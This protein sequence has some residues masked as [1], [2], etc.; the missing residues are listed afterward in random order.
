MKTPH[1]FLFRLSVLL[2]FA[3]SA[4]ILRAASLH[5]NVSFDCEK[6]YINVELSVTD[7]QSAET[8]L[9]LPVWAPGYYLIVDYPKNVVDFAVKDAAGNDI[10]WTKVN[11]NGWNIANG[12]N[13]E[14]TVTYR[15]YANAQSVAEA[16]VKPDKAFVPINGVLMYVENEKDHPVTVTFDLPADWKHISTGL[17]KVEG[18]PHTYTAPSFDVL[19]DC[20]VYLG[21][22]TLIHFDVEGRPYELALETP[23]DIENT[24]FVEDLKKMIAT[25]T[26]MIGHV[27]YHHYTFILMGAGR[28]GLEHTNSQACFTDG[29]FW[30]SDRNYYLNFFSFITHEFFHLYNVKTI[31]PIELGP[32]DYDREVHTPSLWISEGFTVYYEPLLMRRAGLITQAEALAKMSEWLGIIENSEGRK[33]MSL[34]Q[35]SYDIWLNFFNSNANTDT[36][37]SYYNKGP[38][39]GLLMDIEIRRLTSNQRSLDDVMR[40]LYRDFYQQKQRGF[41]EEEFWAVCAKVAGTPLTEMREYVDT[42]KEIDYTRYLGYAGLEVDLTPLP[43]QGDGT[44][45]IRSWQLKPKTECTPQER[46]IRD[47]II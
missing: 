43:E 23:Y 40:T 20:P 17:D 34:R 45:T 8:M 47:S 15:V 7:L 12:K 18:R 32:F 31:R 25:T 14:V 22:Q 24:T 10:R 39:L 28:G 13:Q 35:S 44:V 16:M 36:R 46:A 1:S 9:R 27:P 11:K 26:G 3:I 42:T 41:T 21:N 19:Y 38:I 6:Q 2:L 29:S 33:H 30:F 5:Y 4:Q 37:I